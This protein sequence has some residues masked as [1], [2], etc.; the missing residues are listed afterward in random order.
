[1]R[2]FSQ[3]TLLSF[4]VKAAETDTEGMGEAEAEAATLVTTKSGTI[5]QTKSLKGSGISDSNPHLGEVLAE[6]IPELLAEIRLNVVDK[7]SG[8]VLGTETILANAADRINCWKIKSRLQ[9]CL[10][11][12]FSAEKLKPLGIIATN[13]LR[14]KPRK[15]ILQV[16]DLFS[17]SSEDDDND[18]ERFM[19]DLFAKRNASDKKAGEGMFLRNIGRVCRSYE[20]LP[21]CGGVCNS[22][23]GHLDLVV[24]IVDLTLC[25]SC[26]GGS[27]HGTTTLYVP[28]SW[29]AKQL[30][31]ALA[32][33]RNVT[34]SENSLKKHFFANNS[35]FVETPDAEKNAGKEI[36]K[37]FVGLE[38]CINLYLVVDGK[39]ASK[40]LEENFSIP[41]TNITMAAVISL[42]KVA[43]KVPVHRVPKSGLPD[44]IEVTV[45][46]PEDVSKTQNR[47]NL[48]RNVKV[49]LQAS[50]HWGKLVE[51][52]A[53]MISTDE[54]PFTPKL[55]MNA[56]GGFEIVIEQIG[57]RVK[58]LT[59]KE[60]ECDYSPDTTVTELK[61]MIQKKEGIPPDQQRI[62][63]SG[64]QLEDSRTLKEYG[65][66]PGSTVHLVVSS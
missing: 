52:A 3:G 49:M 54:V 27:L 12:N 34:G 48:E 15:Q 55:N 64:K 63:F 36:W 6:F 42:K 28:T 21:K 33:T 47:E 45:P 30:I 5:V 13:N 59:G 46:V 44:V 4:T 43:I 51:T 40:P 9:K 23:Y 50:A 29:T 58:T 10:G 41:D 66:R 22:R 53:G 35:V 26:S 7:S 56:E 20:D 14:V 2:K 37:K 18:T 62:I 17:T 16:D 61:D 39:P 60:I 11:S 1:M 65:V 57:I 24:D 38:D 8:K 32:R 25:F 19:T 31:L